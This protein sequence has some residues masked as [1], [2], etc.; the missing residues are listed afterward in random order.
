MVMTQDSS[1][2][3]C[4]CTSAAL[5]D[6]PPSSESLETPV[7]QNSPAAPPPTPTCGKKTR[8]F[9]VPLLNSDESLSDEDLRPIGRVLS[10]LHNEDNLIPSPEIYS[11]V[12]SG[13]YKELV[14]I[15]L[16]LNRWSGNVSFIGAR[17]DWGSPVELGQKQDWTLIL[18]VRSPSSGMGIAVKITLSAMNFEE[19]SPWGISYDGLTATQFWLKS[20]DP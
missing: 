1:I 6:L 7:M 5:S 4:S 18:N 16:R 12:I 11:F 20:K 14:H 10:V 13:T 9:P 15:L 2:G 3:S 19:A 17:L 8:V